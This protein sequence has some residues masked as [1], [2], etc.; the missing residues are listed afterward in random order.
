MATTVLGR[1]VGQRYTTQITS[2]HHAIVADEPAPEGDDLGPTPYEL[3]LSA[4]GACTSMT[5]LMYA[6][7]KGWPLREV[8]VELTHDRVHAQDCVDCEDDGSRIELIRRQVV[9]VGPLTAE[10]RERLQEIA[11]RCPVHRTLLA[12]PRIEDV[13]VSEDGS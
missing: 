12:P 6:R 1:S 5:L 4:L 2:Q 11:T 3:L 13:F 9:L 10:Q 8:Q 7:R